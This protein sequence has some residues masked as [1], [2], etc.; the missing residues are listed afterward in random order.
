M[1]GTGSPDMLVLISVHVNVDE[2]CP[3]SSIQAGQNERPLEV[4]FSKCS[5]N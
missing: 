3:P 1:Q 2:E 5:L 4:I